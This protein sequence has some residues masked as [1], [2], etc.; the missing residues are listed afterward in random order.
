M[1]EAASANT[2][3]LFLKLQRFQISALL[4]VFLA[5]RFLLLTFLL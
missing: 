1:K 5:V 3:V 4:F 2:H